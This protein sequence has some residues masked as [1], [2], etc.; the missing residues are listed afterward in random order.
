MRIDSKSVGCQFESD[1]GHQNER[2][3]M[4]M[5]VTQLIELLKKTEVFGDCSVVMHDNALVLCNEI[6]GELEGIGCIK[7]HENGK[8]QVY[9]EGF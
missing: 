9:D 3:K 5:K 4:Q 7:I 2:R 8:L 1:L 6:D